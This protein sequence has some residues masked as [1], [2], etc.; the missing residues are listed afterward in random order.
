MKLFRSKFHFRIRNWTFIWCG[1]EMIPI[2]FTVPVNTK[3][4]SLPSHF[5][6]YF[7]IQN[8]HGFW[9]WS[10]GSP[11]TEIRSLKIF[12]RKIKRKK[13]SS[14]RTFGRCPSLP[15]RI[16][17]LPLIA[18]GRAAKRA[19]YGGAL[20]GVSHRPSGVIC[21]KRSSSAAPGHGGKKNQGVQPKKDWPSDCEK[22]Q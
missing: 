12:S 2:D 21:L 20:I 22:I 17:T 1:F 10:Y 5:F 6:L 4:G 8:W 14:K 3:S 7:L 13:I 19:S 16:V 18:Q 11:S 9:N 15:R